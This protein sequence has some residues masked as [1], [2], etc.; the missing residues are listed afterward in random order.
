MWQQYFRVSLIGLMGAAVLSGL[1]IAGPRPIA[2]NT[3]LKPVV[4]WF[5]R[6][7]REYQDAVVKELSVPAGKGTPLAPGQPASEGTNRATVVIER[8]RR[9]LGIETAKAPD[10]PASSTGTDSPIEQAE[11]DQQIERQK[12]ARALEA[13]REAESRRLE[14]EAEKAQKALEA[15]ADPSTVERQKVAAAARVAEAERSKAPPPAAETNVAA[16]PVPPRA[17]APPVATVPQRPA[18]VEKPVVVTPVPETKRPADVAQV[19]SAAPAP[20]AKAVPERPVPPI[21]PVAKPQPPIAAPPVVAQAPAASTEE[22]WNRLPRTSG[23]AGAAKVDRVEAPKVR[24][25]TPDAKTPDAKTGEAKVAASP[26]TDHWNR[27]PRSGEALA[28]SVGAAAEKLAAAASRAGDRIIEG[29]KARLGLVAATPQ[30]EREHPG[31][32]RAGV[33]VVPPATYTVKRGDS[34]WTIARRH[35]ERGQAYTKI[36]RANEAKIA[37]PDLIYPCQKFYLPRRHAWAWGGIV[38][39]PT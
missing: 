9:W 3:T 35:Y 36:V 6:A 7:H 25:A 34:L 37:S 14:A 27:I 24:D 33:P 11:I 4:D 23:A 19:P 16:A 31:C 30:P 39:D 26:A 29:S 38:G 21:P 15:A 8:V 32:K 10:G 1:A 18:D 28:R 17:P 2:E 13:Q 5:E 12:E 22:R 20:P